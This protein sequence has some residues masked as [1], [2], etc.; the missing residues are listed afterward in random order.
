MKR[1]DPVF[2]LWKLTKENGMK[3][4]LEFIIEQATTT[5]QNY[6][7]E[8][9]HR[10]TKLLEQIQS[11]MPN[12]DEY[13]QMKNHV[14]LMEM[15]IGTLETTQSTIERRFQDFNLKVDKKVEVIAFNE[16]IKLINLN[17]RKVSFDLI[18][19]FSMYYLN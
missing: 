13:Q 2:E 17:L 4:S 12:A 1:L 9:L 14:F 8:K 19:S 15:K 7:N 16:E 18:I 3:S 5:S 10:W 11:Q 6:V